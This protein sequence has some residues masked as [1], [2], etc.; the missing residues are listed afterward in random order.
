MNSTFFLSILANF[1]W[2]EQPTADRH[3][4]FSYFAV[5]FYHLPMTFHCIRLR[6]HLC[7]S[8]FEFP[9]HIS[10]NSLYSNRTH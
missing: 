9:P 10:I 8:R 1:S 3:V 4:S 7:F 6:P 5:M 2:H